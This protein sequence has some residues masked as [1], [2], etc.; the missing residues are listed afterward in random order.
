MSK[1]SSFQVVCSLMGN[2]WLW[3]YTKVLLLTHMIISAVSIFFLIYLIEQY[4]YVNNAITYVYT[5]ISLWLCINSYIGLLKLT[6][7]GYKYNL[8]YL[9]FV[10]CGTIFFKLITYDLKLANI[11]VS[12]I[13]PILRSV[14]YLILNLLYFKKRRRLFSHVWTAAAEPEA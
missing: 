8:A 5:A 4:T 2:R 13:G 6:E 12:V 14:L 7:K 9:W 3:F 10:A 11:T 1:N